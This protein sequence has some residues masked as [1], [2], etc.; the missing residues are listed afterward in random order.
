[1]PLTFGDVFKVTENA[2][3]DYNADVAYAPDRSV[4]V[5]YTR[6]SFA[7]GKQGLY[8]RKRKRNK[9]WLDEIRVDYFVTDSV[10]VDADVNLPENSGTAGRN[11]WVDGAG[12]V[13]IAWVQAGRGTTPA[14]R[15]IC[16]RR[17]QNNGNEDSYGTPTD[18]YFRDSAA[19]AVLQ[20]ISMAVS[21]VDGTVWFASVLS[22]GTL[23]VVTYKNATESSLTL[24]SDR[25]ET[26]P[27]VN[28]GTQTSATENT[29]IYADR[30]GG[31]HVGYFEANSTNWAV[32]YAY[33]AHGDPK[34]TAPGVT[35]LRTPEL[36][37]GSTGS[38]GITRAFL[39][40]VARNSS[41]V[42]VCYLL[43]NTGTNHVVWVSSHTRPGG[44]WTHTQISDGT[45][46]QRWTMS[47]DQQSAVG[48]AVT[49]WGQHSGTSGLYY[50]EEFGGTWAAQALGVA[51]TVSG[52]RTFNSFG[53]VS[54]QRCRFRSFARTPYQLGFFNPVVG[55]LV[56][57]WTQA[58][59]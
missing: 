57:V 1:M 26:P 41:D 59:V 39:N 45:S 14:N 10:A 36:V 32:T 58:D 47:I 15:T 18:V 17:L 40:I 22:S 24:P 30:E 13:H 20:A 49:I 11:I 27:F 29:T 7:V 34:R 43:V 9:T 33:R 48:Y 31:I 5:L 2:D 42:R 53:D 16:Y 12:D 6:T 25:D 50:A 44:P 52:V 46:S 3:T 23:P 4:W 56:T 37:I 55:Q 19:G 54:S 35:S 51:G 8:L 28:S 21:P 38:L